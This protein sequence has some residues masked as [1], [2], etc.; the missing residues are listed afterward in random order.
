MTCVAAVSVRPVPAAF[1]PRMSMSKPA[2]DLRCFWKR[3]TISCLLGTRRVT[4]DDVDTF[5]TKHMANYLRKSELHLPVFDENENT[6]VRGFDAP[7]DVDNRVKTCALGHELVRRRASGVARVY[8]DRPNMVQH[9][10]F[11]SWPPVGQL[12]LRNVIASAWT[13]GISRG[14]R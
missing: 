13:F 3:L 4:A 10:Q 6:L 9:L 11:C 2:S 12:Q 5:E 14:C 7:Q 1:G 8:R